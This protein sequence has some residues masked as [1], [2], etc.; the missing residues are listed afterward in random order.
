MTICPTGTSEQ[1]S[2]GEFKKNGIYHQ[3]QEQEKLFPPKRDTKLYQF[4]IGSDSSGASS[5]NWSGPN[6]MLSLGAESKKYTGRLFSFSSGGS[7]RKSSIGEQNGP[8]D[9]GSSVKIA[10]KEEVIK[11]EANLS[12]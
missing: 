6:S 9:W 5:G 2:G 4:E 7:S 10:L 12:A 3:G 11:K 1:F 8:F